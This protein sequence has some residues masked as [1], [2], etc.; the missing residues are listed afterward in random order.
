MKTPFVMPGKN[1]FIVLLTILTL[2]AVGQNQVSKWYFGNN[3]G[4]DFM[5][6]PPTILTNGQISTT[7]GVATIADAAGN[8]LFYTDGV[9]IW[10]KTHAVMSNGT[11][12]T[13]NPSC[14]QSGIIVRKPGSNT[15][16]YVFTQGATAPLAYS[17]VD[18]TQN[19]GN[20]AVTIKNTTLAINNTEKLTSAWHCNGTDVWIL[21]HNNMSKDF[22]AFLVTSAG[23][24]PVPVI[25]STGTGGDWNLGHLKVSPDGTRLGAAMHAQGKF[26]VFDFDNTTGT[27]SNPIPL[28]SGLTYAY[29]C[30][31]SPNSK[32]FYGTRELDP[33]IIQ[34]DVCGSSTAAVVASQNTVG[35]G[36]GMTEFGAMQLGP[37]QKIY[38]ARYIDGYLSTL[39]NPNVYGLGCNFVNQSQSLGSKKSTLGLP[40]FVASLFVPA[41]PAF[42]YSTSCNESQ[43]SV[44]TVTYSAGGCNGTV[45]TAAYNW[46]FGDVGS[47]AAN[48]SNLQNPTHNFSSSGT[49]TVLL[50]VS[51]PCGGADTVKQVLTTSSITFSASGTSTICSGNSTTLTASGAS[52]Y[53]WDN[54]MQGPLIVVKPTQSTYYIVYAFNADSSCKAHQILH[55]NV[56]KCVGIEEQ[57]GLLSFTAY[58]NPNSGLLQIESGATGTL[59]IFNQLG[60]ITLRKEVGAGKQSVDIS[61][62]S[63]GFYY[64]KFSNSKT[65]KTMRLEKIK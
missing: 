59:E 13:G 5:T 45:T 65:C 16:Y 29:G 17:T 23:V 37:D 38:I 54:G 42:S 9:K 60:A 11:G 10:D 28:D 41:T 36:T 55:V 57:D 39:D 15:I 52:T 64:V 58:P 19:G 26:E 22:L 30:E 2:S 40:N 31:F 56:L 7:E 33:Q 6:T 21:T 1:Q 24:N 12:L 47:G 14:T 27:V 46:N 43:F 51:R 48:T 49:F 62:L 3:A 8:L 44:P 35:F 20:G 4:L 61:E 32:L 53:S 34:W 63:A 25:S 18:M 50:A